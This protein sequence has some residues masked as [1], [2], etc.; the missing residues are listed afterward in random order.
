[1]TSWP[2]PWWERQDRKAARAVALRRIATAL[3]ALAFAAVLL[4]LVAPAGA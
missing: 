4:A 3:A 2:D 1:M